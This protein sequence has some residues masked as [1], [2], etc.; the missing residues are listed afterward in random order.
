MNPKRQS[1]PPPGRAGGRTAQV[2]SPVAATTARH[3]RRAV[4]IVLRR[5]NG[6][7]GP[8]ERPASDACEWD[9]AAMRSTEI[10]TAFWEDVWNAH[11]LDAID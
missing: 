6:P 7:R 4:R 10:V 9:G 8:V 5:W 1:A 3:A 11:D 2:V